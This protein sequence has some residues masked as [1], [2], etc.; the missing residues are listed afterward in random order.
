LPEPPGRRAR[1]ASA[2]ARLRTDG[3]DRYGLGL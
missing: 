3:G 2:V 1:V